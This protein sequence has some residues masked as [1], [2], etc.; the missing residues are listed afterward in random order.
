MALSG[1]QA[2]ARLAAWLGR[3]LGAPVEI[4]A[5]RKLSGGAIQENWLVEAV[6]GKDARA[7][8]LRKDAAA[9]I[10]ASHSRKDEFALITA[11]WQ[12]GV[13][14]P[15]PVAFC[16]DDSVIGGPFALMAKVEGVG[17]G[18][19]IVKDMSL[20][21]DRAALA[22]RLGAELAAIHRV[23]PPQAHLPLADLAFLG[24]PP[25]EPAL[26]DIAWL[27]S[28]LD[29]MGAARPAL[30]WALRWAELNQPRPP[31]VTLV[32]RDFRTGNYMVDEH[33]LTAILDWEFAG[34]GDPMSDLGWFCAECWRFGRRDLE[35][36]GIGPRDAFER[37]YRDAGGLPIDREAIAFWEVMAHVR[38]A[39]IALQQGARH[40]SGDEFSLEHALTGRIAAELELAA[41]RMTAPA[42]WRAA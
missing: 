3:T 4:T 9:T 26:A 15:E 39:V 14:V 37:G 20:G 17:F 22:S 40:A 19:K 23:R 33:G 11:A 41:L 7:F 32:H 2:Q 31:A 16:P 35:A 36:G 27:R 42:R 18:P 21:G 5:A 28:A 34:W 10:S 13:T 1:P 38:W 6:V 29:H 25:D 12:A 24:P 8:V 30:D